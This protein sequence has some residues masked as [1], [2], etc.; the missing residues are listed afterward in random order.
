MGDVDEGD[1]GVMSVTTAVAV[2][3][4]VAV[5][6]TAVAYVGFSG[7]WRRRRKTCTKTFKSARVGLPR[8]S[9]NRSRL[10]PTLRSCTALGMRAQLKKTHTYIH[11][12]IHTC[13]TNIHTYI[14]CMHT[15]IH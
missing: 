8:R 3:T 14:A 4:A 5:V 12:Y 2:A 11:T 10:S 6:A 13:I 7:C 15:Y 1:V 9:K